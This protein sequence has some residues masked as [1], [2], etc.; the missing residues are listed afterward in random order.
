M[1][2]RL[3]S[4]VILHNFVREVKRL[5]KIIDLNMKGALIPSFRILKICSH[6]RSSHDCLL[7]VR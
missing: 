2:F 6:I 7:I 3:V 4:K 5:T 1:K